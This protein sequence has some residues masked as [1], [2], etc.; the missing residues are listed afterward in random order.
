MRRP[1]AGRGTSRRT[2]R[3]IGR[4]RTAPRPRAGRTQAATAGHGT[5]LS[6]TFRRPVFFWPTPRQD[7]AQPAGGA[8]AAAIAEAN[9]RA[10]SAGQ[11][12]GGGRMHASFMI[13]RAAL[14]VV[15]MIGFYV[16]ALGIALGLLWVPYAELV[17]A[18]R[19]TPKLAIICIVGALAIL[20]SVLPRRDRFSPPGP[21]LRNERHPRLFKALEAVARATKQA[22]PAEVYL[23]GDVNAWVMQRG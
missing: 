6:R 7:S 19:I 14:A 11:D 18:E 12:H 21:R 23:V 8:G 15:L 2:C 20:L 4:R 3:F 10:K 22:M 1:C 13:G 17:F 16:L 9:S 5:W